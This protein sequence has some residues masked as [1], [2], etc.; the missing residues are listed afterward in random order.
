MDF[1]L[2]PTIGLVVFIGVML[3]RYGFWLLL[4]VQLIGYEAT[5]RVEEPSYRTIW[6]QINGKPVESAPSRKPG[7]PVLYIALALLVW[8]VFYA[9]RRRWR[10][11]LLTGLIMTINPVICWWIFTGIALYAQYR[12]VKGL[13]YQFQ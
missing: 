13:T 11:L 10:F 1:P 7:N 9:L 2:L 12:Q 4:Y 6:Q 5:R 3:Y 8:P